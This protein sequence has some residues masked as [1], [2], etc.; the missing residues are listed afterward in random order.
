MLAMLYFLTWFVISWRIYWQ[1][2]RYQVLTFLLANLGFNMELSLQPRPLNVSKMFLPVNF[3]GCMLHKHIYNIYKPYNRYPCDR[4]YNYIADAVS[5]CACKYRFLTVSTIACT[6]INRSYYCHM[7]TARWFFLNK[8]LPVVSQH[9]Q[10]LFINYQQFS[11]RLS[12]RYIKMILIDDFQIP[13]PY[14]ILVSQQELQ[15]D[16]KYFLF[17]QRF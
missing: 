12:S 5:Q 17:H 11:L 6:L 9:G 10:G 14:I 8:P 1:P 7:C 4:L 3:G 13:R 16:K 2:I 15:I